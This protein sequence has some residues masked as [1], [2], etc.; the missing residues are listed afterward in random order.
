MN[1]NL[2]ADERTL[3]FRIA[4]EDRSRSEVQALVLKLLTE[5][6]PTGI[7]LPSQPMTFSGAYPNRI[8]WIKALR[9]ANPWLGLS[10]AKKICDRFYPDEV[11]NQLLVVDDTYGTH[12]CRACGS[13]D[14][15]QRATN[16]R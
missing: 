6:A 15:V 5:Q 7:I 8:P 3:L 1:T 4:G 12:M 9:E 16:Q 2:T 10:E 13:N 11:L 14:I